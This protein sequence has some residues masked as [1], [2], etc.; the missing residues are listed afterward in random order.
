MTVPNELRRAPAAGA[1]ARLCAAVAPSSRVT[2]VRR[3]PGGLGAGMH[4]L[5]LRAPS[6]VRR[7]LVLRRYSAATL[8]WQPDSPVRAW[9]TLAVLEALGINAPR[10]VWYD[11]DGALFGVPA[12]VMSHLPGRSVIAPRDPQDWARQLAGALAALHRAPLGSVDTGFLPAPGYEPERLLTEARLSLDAAIGHPD[13]AALAAALRRWRPRVEATTPVL[14]HGDYW[15]GNTLWS[16]GRLTAVVDWDQA[17]LNHPGL[18]VGYCRLD[19]FLLAGPQAPAQFLRAYEAAAGWS[20]PQLPFWE[21]LGALR[22]LPDPARF[23]PG[24]H[25]LGRTDISPDE[26]RARYRLFVGRA[27]ADAAAAEA[28]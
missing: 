11:G 6:G 1:L 16:R 12:L 13:G 27:L 2:R 19:L 20:V 4:V 8:R 9:R 7:R 28:R 18:D 21:L 10:P 23:L 24:Y 25:D 5:D 17:E 26:V 3:L 14:V 15:P 22:W